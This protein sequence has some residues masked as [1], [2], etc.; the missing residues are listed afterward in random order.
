MPLSHEQ[1][2]RDAV[3]A[4]VLNWAVRRGLVSKPLPAEAGLDMDRGEIVQPGALQEAVDF[5]AGG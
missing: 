5:L 4:W 1:A 3:G 2:M